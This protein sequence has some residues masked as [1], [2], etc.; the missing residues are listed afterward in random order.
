MRR[1]T[2]HGSDDQE[3]NLAKLQAGR[4]PVPV[5]EG[6][7]VFGGAP[8]PQRAPTGGRPEYGDVRDFKAEQRPLRDFPQRQT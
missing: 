4:V 5:L 3:Q 7:A 8:F 2:K 1:L 6:R